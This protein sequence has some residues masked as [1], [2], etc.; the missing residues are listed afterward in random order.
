MMHMNTAHFVLLQQL[1]DI[2]LL[3]CIAVAITLLQLL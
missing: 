2:L 3:V 1:H